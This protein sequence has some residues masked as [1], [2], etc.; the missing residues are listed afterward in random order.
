MCVILCARLTF[1]GY[2]WGWM[3]ELLLV[4]WIKLSMLKVWYSLCETY[5]FWVSMG[6]E[7]G[8]VMDLFDQTFDGAPVDVWSREQWAPRRTQATV[9]LAEG[10]LQNS[11]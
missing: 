8:F 2:L 11:F 4:C 7:G 1:S 10:G 5:I 6:L 9:A 3:E